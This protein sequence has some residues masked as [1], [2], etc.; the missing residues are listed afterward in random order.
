MCAARQDPGCVLSPHHHSSRSSPRRTRKMCQ[1]GLRPV[2]QYPLASHRRMCTANWDSKH[3]P[4][5]HWSGSHEGAEKYKEKNEVPVDSVQKRDHHSK[6]Y[7]QLWVS[8][9]PCHKQVSQIF[10]TT[11]ASLIPA[12]AFTYISTCEGGMPILHF[13]KWPPLISS[14]SQMETSL[15]GLP[16]KFDEI[17]MCSTNCFITAMYLQELFLHWSASNQRCRNFETTEV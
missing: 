1:Q 14:L 3:N 16:H 6:R 11:S 10:I 4:S 12:L 7:L 15:A 17:F 5:R 13:A 8:E 9:V 2:Q